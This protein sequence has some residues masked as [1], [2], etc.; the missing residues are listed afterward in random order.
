MSLTV[1]DRRCDGGTVP[2]VKVAYRPHLCMHCDKAPCIASCAVPGGSTE[3]TD[4]YGDFWFEGLEDGVH[5]LA[6]RHGD[7]SRDFA[8]LNT[9]ERDINLGDIPLT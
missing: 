5:D 6:I 4:S 7:R 3:E 2:K 1:D 8:G 9:A